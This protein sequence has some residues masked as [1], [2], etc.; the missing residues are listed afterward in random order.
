MSFPITPYKIKKGFL[1]WKH[2]GTREF[3][4]RLMDRMEPED[5]PYEPWFQSHR[6]GDAQLMRQKEQAADTDPLVSILVPAFHTPTRFLEELIDSVEAQSYQNWELV[7]ADAGAADDAGDGEGSVRSVT[8]EREKKDCRV[9]YV[10]LADNYGI[11]E[12]TNRAIAAA[13]GVYIGF[14]DHDDLLEP[15]AIYEMM[16]AAREKGA[17]MLY[18]DEDKVSADG[19][20]HFQPHFKPEFNLDLLRSNN[21]IT[22]FLVVKKA[23]AEEAGG[24]DPELSGA[25]DHDFIFRCAEKAEGIARVPRILYHWRTH[26]ASTAD[27]PMSKTYAYEAGKKA[28]E[29]SLRRAGEKGT[30]ELLPDFGFYRVRYPVDGCPKVS[31]IIPNKDEHEALDQCIRSVLDTN[32]PNLEII[33]VENNSTERETFEYYRKL[34]QSNE[35]NIRLV[36]WRKGFNY[37]AINNY[38]VS[39]ARGDYFLFL[40]N[41]VRGTIS[42]DWL[43]EMLGVCQRPDVGAVGAKLYY[44]DNKVQSAGI[45][46]GIGGIAGSMFVDLPRGRGGYMHKASIMQDL[47]AVTAACM[48]VKREAFEKAGGFTEELAVAFND[49]DFCLKIG[50]CGYRIVYDPYA[51]LYHDESRTRGAEDTKEKVRRFQ[52]EIEYMRSHWTDILIHGDPN[53][54]PNLSLKKWNYSLKV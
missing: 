1:Y 43:T 49:V 51:E 20:K 35:E 8:A 46:I 17:D 16:R 44:P 14:L 47:S 10:P 39:F 22:H 29:G 23:L 7:I 33:I 45:V 24:F 52:S 31:V 25:Q 9:R 12:N 34:S 19:S 32:Y 28:V 38:G 13:R 21:Y 2:F 50:Q 4:N 42:T 18:S 15:D 3:I 5:V 41:D 36:R 26:E 30:V 27:N 11:A 40:N 54:N 48:L 37:S 6:A 53:Y